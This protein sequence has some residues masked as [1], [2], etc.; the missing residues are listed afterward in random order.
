MKIGPQDKPSAAD[1]AVAQNRGDSRIGEPPRA[2]LVRA[3]GL[4][5]ALEAASQ[6]TEVRLS[7]AASAMA[8]A[9]AAAAGQ[10]VD[11]DK[12]QRVQAALAQ[13]QYRVNPEAI[14]DQLIT[15]AQAFLAPRRG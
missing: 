5:S 14:A 10:E 15:D 8:M 2:S 6:G 12:V 3:G 11:L 13:G 9:Q 1:V 7:D 4:A